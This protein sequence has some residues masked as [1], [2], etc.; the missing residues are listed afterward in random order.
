MADGAAEAAAL[1]VPEKAAAEAAAVVSA[2]AQ[3]AARRERM[4]DSWRPERD[5]RAGSQGRWRAGHTGAGHERKPL[6]ANE[7]VHGPSD[8]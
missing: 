6:T 2:A 5:G 3:S 8:S 7:V 4:V 1:P